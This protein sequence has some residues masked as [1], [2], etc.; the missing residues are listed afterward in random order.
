MS[1][2]LSY[3]NIDLVMKGQDQHRG[4]QFVHSRG[5]RKGA[6]TLG[7]GELGPR[8]CWG[9]L[10]YAIKNQLGHPKPA[11]RGFGTKYLHWGIFL[12]LRWFF[13][14]WEYFEFKSP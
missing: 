4:T 10:S 6:V 8:N 3:Q 14:A 9:Q 1:G 7:R 2:S 5:A 13:M 11:T 12:A